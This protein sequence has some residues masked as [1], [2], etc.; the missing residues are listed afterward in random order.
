MWFLL[1]IAALPADTWTTRTAR[2]EGAAISV[3][4]AALAVQ[5]T[6]QGIADSGRVKD[7][8][9]LHSLASDLDRRVISARLAAS[10]MDQ[11]E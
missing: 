11:T 5:T 10:V 8:A 4:E 7:V 6:A 2:M 3:K 9:T 1:L